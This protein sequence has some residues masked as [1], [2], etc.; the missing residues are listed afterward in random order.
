[1]EFNFNEEYENNNL[2]INEYINSD[3]ID[4]NTDISVGWTSVCFNETISYYTDCN[5][6]SSN[7][8]PE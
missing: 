4:I 3:D 7:T 1:M 2:M 6:K 8:S 5:L